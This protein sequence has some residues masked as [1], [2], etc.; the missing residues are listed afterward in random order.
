MQGDRPT[1][2][3]YVPRLSLSG[4]AAGRYDARVTAIW[5]REGSNWK[6]LS[7][8]GFPDEASLHRLVEEAP[9]GLDVHF[10]PGYDHAFT[11]E[12]MI[13]KGLMPHSSDLI[14]ALEPPP[15]VIVDPAT[16]KV[17]HEEHEPLPP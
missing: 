9:Q 5:G 12:E 7:P 10:P 16:G 2:Q 1:P 4:G 13:E 8:A 11:R 3:R 17:V 14:P 6:L 15:E